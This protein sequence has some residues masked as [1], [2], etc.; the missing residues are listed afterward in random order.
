MNVDLDSLKTEILD[1]LAKQDFVIFYGYSRLAE[2]DSFVA[3]DT[4]RMPDYQTFLSAAKKAGVRMVVYH[5]R[6]FTGAHMEEASERLEE[7]DI[8]PDEQRQFE[9]KLREFRGYEGFT[10]ALELSFDFEGRIYMFNLRAV[11]YEEYLDTLEELDA[12]AP[13]EDEDEGGMG[14][15]YSSN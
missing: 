12:F 14:G 8:P 15:F 1:Y 13:D 5:H 9:R 4:D 7:A 11:W 6:E 3:W 2:S 10:C